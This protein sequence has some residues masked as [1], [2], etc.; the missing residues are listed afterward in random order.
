MALRVLAV[1]VALM[2]LVLAALGRRRFATGFAAVVRLDLQ[3]HML[4]AEVI[5][6]AA[7]QFTAQHIGIGAVA[8]HDVRGQCRRAG[9]QRPHVQVMHVQHG[10]VAG[11]AI[12]HLGHVHA[13]G[14][15][16]QQHV[17][18]LAHQ[19]VGARQYPQADQ[20][21][22]D[23]VDRLPAG[24]LDQQR[25]G[26]HRH[27]AQHVRP[28]F[29]VGALHVEALAAA[30]LQQAHRDQVDDEARGGDHQHAGGSD[31]LRLAETSHR[32]PQD[33]GGDHEQHRA[34][35]HRAQR[36]Q[37]CIA[38]GAPCIRRA[39]AQSHRHQRDHQRQ[40]VGGHVRGIGQQRQAVGPERAHHFDDEE[41]GGDRGRGPWQQLLCDG[42]RL[43]VR[44]WGNYHGGYN[45]AGHAA[46]H[47]AGPGATGARPVAPGPP[48]RS[49]RS[50]VRVRSE[51]EAQAG[52]VRATRLVIGRRTG[53]AAVGLAE[54]AL[55][56]QVVHT[57]AEADRLGH[58]VARAHAPDVVS[59][60]I[61]Q[62]ERRIAGAGAARIIVDVG[63]GRLLPAIEAWC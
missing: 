32:L 59:P 58:P 38:V 63:G 45:I 6:Q 21:G 12:A 55:V 16:F 30:G 7:T 29:Q 2:A 40:C 22:Q 49:Q 9:S 34:V 28:H 27:R 62:R 24:P 10:R 8:H 5:V 56:G 42:R 44:A 54:Q 17:D 57:E 31:L 35:D 43:R 4:D 48:R 15:A 51:A 13:L 53:I 14:H 20:H 19:H 18:R 52:P 60:A 39:P 50:E 11:Q 46:P 61:L 36:F 26:D 3:R 33:V 25:A 41:G 47:R 37:A 23:R 1:V